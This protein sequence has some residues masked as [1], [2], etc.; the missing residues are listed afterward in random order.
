M[1]DLR[2]VSFVDS[3]GLHA[4][5]Q[6]S[7]RAKANRHRMVLIGARPSTRRLFALT[8]TEFLLDEQEARPSS[9]DSRGSVTQAI[10]WSSP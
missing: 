6:A 2:D 7:E 4:F 8:G 5:L 1:L 9:A 3:S 10:R